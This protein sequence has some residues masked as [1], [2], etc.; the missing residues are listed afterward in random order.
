MASLTQTVV[1]RLNSVIKTVND[2]I[3]NAIKTEGLPGATTPLGPTDLVRVVQAGVSKKV[4]IQDLASIGTA[5]QKIQY[6]DVL[7][8]GNQGNTTTQLEVGDYVTR[9]WGTSPTQEFW[10]VAKYNGP[11]PNLKTSYTV[12]RHLEEL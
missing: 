3:K 7:I 1:S 4:E 12:L 9:V 2:I 11:D 6:G 10:L 8:W 5:I